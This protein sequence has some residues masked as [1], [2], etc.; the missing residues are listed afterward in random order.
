M[1]KYRFMANAILGLVVGVCGAYNL[2]AAQQ[3]SGANGIPAHL[4]VTVEPHHG[5]DVPVINREDVMVYE[6]KDRDTVTEWI[7]AQGDRAGLELFVLIDDGSD[8]SLGTQLDDL[9]KFI[10]KQ[11]A[12]TLIGIAYMQDG[13]ARIA[14]NPT[15]DHA[16]AAKA[17]R[18][19]MG[20][21]GGNGSPYFS[22]TDLI[23]RWPESTSRREVLMAS[24]G[25]DVNY[26]TG[27]LQDPYV[28][29]AIDVAQRAGILVSAIYTPGVGHLGHSY[30][31]TYWGQLYLA[32][33][34]EMT[35]GE[36]YYIG[37][38]G[39]PV[40]FTPYLDDLEHRVGH[41]YFLT[42]LAKPPK[43]AGWQ[44]VKLRTEVPKVDLISAGR[45]W[46]S[47]EGK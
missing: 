23:K 43:K 25:I 29:E 38:S 8:S 12:S 46:V 4:V 16:L 33:L 40:S 6:G 20:I 7:P 14:Q 2:A 28:E 34:A 42:F 47:P 36:A 22:L 26:G 5:S 19:P 41:Q 11:P 18:L 39:P 37:F 24:D 13:I 45:V 21:R 31:Q 17:L 3:A 15:N 9:R 10:D 30:W 27:D 32:R 44:M 35:G 1:N